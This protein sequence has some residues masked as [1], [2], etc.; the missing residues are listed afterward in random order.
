MARNRWWSPIKAPLKPDDELQLWA[1]S[2]GAS[3]WIVDL[4]PYETARVAGSVVKL[5]IDPIAGDIDAYVWDGT[6]YL[7]ARWLIVR[8]TP[9]VAVAPG[10]RVLLIGMPVSEHDSIVMVEPLFELLEPEVA[11]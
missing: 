2:T 5:R 3:C 11:S 10:R 1:V 9:Q 4:E 8:P 7:I 6:G